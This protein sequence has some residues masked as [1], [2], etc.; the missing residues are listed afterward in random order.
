M[1]LF[2]CIKCKKNSKMK[3]NEYQKKRYEKV[4]DAKVIL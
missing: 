3:I 4:M 1:S 2:V